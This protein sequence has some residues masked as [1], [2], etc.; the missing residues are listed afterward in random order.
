MGAEA[1]GDAT[2]GQRHDRGGE[3]VEVEREREDR[4]GF[5]A[6]AWGEQVGGTQDEQGGGDVACLERGDRAE[7]PPEVAVE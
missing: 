6:A 3:G 4:G 5:G 1:V 7:E 2:G